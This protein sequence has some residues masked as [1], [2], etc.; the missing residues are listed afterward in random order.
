[1]EPEVFLLTVGL[2][3]VVVFFTLFVLFR[4]GRDRKGSE[5]RGG[6]E[7][8]DFSGDMYGMH[9][10]MRGGHG[11]EITQS[12][13]DEHWA[14]INKTLDEFHTTANNAISELNDKY[15]EMLFLYSLIDDKKKEVLY[16]SSTDPLSISKKPE[17]V[18]KPRPVVEKGRS[19]HPR[20]KDIINLSKQGLSV[21]EIAQELNV[22][23]DMVSLILEMGKAR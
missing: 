6:I 10:N 21:S 8:Q 20:R 3:I 19:N 22:G 1:M 16:T 18:A 17:P 5:W 7:R 2:G 13:L 14:Q 12:K 15:Q 23:Q 9:G 11:S 4:K